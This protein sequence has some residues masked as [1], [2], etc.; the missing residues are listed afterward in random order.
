[1][2]TSPKPEASAQLKGAVNEIMRYLHVR[3]FAFAGP[4]PS[5][6]EGQQAQRTGSWETSLYRKWRG[7]SLAK[8]L[9]PSATK[10]QKYSI[11]PTISTRPAYPQSPMDNT[12]RTSSSSAEGAA[13][14]LESNVV[15]FRS[16]AYQIAV[17]FLFLGE[18]FFYDYCLS[19]YSHTIQDFNMRSPARQCTFSG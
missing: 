5:D 16:G 9:T 18:R 7:F 1:M 17:A 15:V 14:L 10:S 4:T 2:N 12:T 11:T 8:T 6:V 13:N 19:R 3:N